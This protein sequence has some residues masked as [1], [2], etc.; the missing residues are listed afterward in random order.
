MMS[1][2]LTSTFFALMRFAT[3][4]KH[5]VTV[6]ARPSGM[7]AT[8]TIMKPLTKHVKKDTP[9]AMPMTKSVD[10]D[11]SANIAMMLTNRLIS[12]CSKLSST[13][14]EPA[15]RVAIVPIIVSFAVRITTPNPEPCM[16][17]DDENAIFLASSGLSLAAFTTAATGFD[18][19]VNDEFSN[20]KSFV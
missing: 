3:T 6:A 1:M 10:A 18:S 12:F 7:F 8:R 5:D 4:A 14:P 9:R 17:N 15:A 19:P 11:A 13:T 20:F 2:R 16:T